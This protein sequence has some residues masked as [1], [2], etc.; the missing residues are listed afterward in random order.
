M[1]DQK[2]MW[3]QKFKI[4]FKIGKNGKVKALGN[5]GTFKLKGWNNFVI[6]LQYVLHFKGVYFGN[7][8]KASNTFILKKIESLG[9]IDKQ[10]PS[11]WRCANFL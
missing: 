5:T 11:N 2:G 3:W 9:T 10:D 8:K 7:Q 1:V 4:F 6:I